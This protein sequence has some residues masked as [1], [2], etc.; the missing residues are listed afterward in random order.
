MMYRFFRQHFLAAFYACIASGVGSTVAAAD[1][2]QNTIAMEN[3]ITTQ[4][5]SELA[6]ILPPRSF[7]VVTS[8][9]VRTT[10]VR[11][12]SEGESIVIKRSD[13]GKQSLDL[14][15]FGPGLNTDSDEPTARE[16]Q[17]Y[18]M[19]EKNELDRIN[20]TV[21]TDVDVPA[22]RLATAKSILNRRLAASYGAKAAVTFQTAPLG[23][24]WKP[25]PPPVAEE[26]SLG[27]P[28]PFAKLGTKDLTRGLLIF[29]GLIAA[30]L[31]FRRIFR[32][33][34]PLS[35][36]MD[37]RK[38]DDT[39]DMFASPRHDALP[40]SAYTPG[41]PPP[42][43]LPELPPPLNE[44]PDFTFKA[45]AQAA[46]QLVEE[47]ASDPVAARS[48]LTRLT[49][50][51]RGLLHACFQTNALRA[52]FD[53]L[54]GPLVSDG[55]VEAPPTEA[56]ARIDGLRT[57]TAELQ[58]YRKLMLLQRRQPFGFLTLLAP[59]EILRLL[60]GE[61][62]AT[63][64]VAF[65]QL[66]PTLTADVLRLMEDEPKKGLL[67]AL[68]SK[69]PRLSATDL[70][71]AEEALRSKAESMP[72]NIFSP[73]L[74]THSLADLIVGS[75]ENPRALLSDLVREDRSLLQRHGHHLITFDDFLNESVERVAYCLEKVSNESLA[76][77][78]T[79]LHDSQRARLVSALGEGR[80]RV[81]HSLA[82]SL[83]NASTDGDISS[84]RSQ[85]LK[86]Y[87]QMIA[88]ER[89]QDVRQ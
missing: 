18:R 44:S 76:V 30:W 53:S 6:T 19:V 36:G 37:L 11:E 17:T 25:Q 86:S 69:V 63:I 78:A 81:V 58:Q 4:L 74:A 31:I 47:V 89:R 16:R 33:H 51:N 88:L 87:Q 82:Q 85:V 59:Q 29:G 2:V 1:S 49:P 5:T 77:A 75:S 67:T 10:N 15:G 38:N 41:L 9:T 22:D 72:Q 26:S 40:P 46:E 7:A 54:M 23:G 14:P 12:L 42:R 45:L 35:R 83:G 60:N 73:A 43:T 71:A 56:A 3:A 32:R 84:A 61:T 50:A 79:G 13:E 57:L 64:V 65:S 28:G 39:I 20:V 21:V 55:P 62:P 27:L 70:A 52:A 68:S 24:D 48:F 66:P 34:Q 8:A 80:R